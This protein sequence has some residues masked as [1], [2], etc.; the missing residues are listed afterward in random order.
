VTAARGEE[1]VA[2]VPVAAGD[3]L[4]IGENVERR[5]DFLA[6]AAARRARPPH[7]YG[8][9]H[10]TWP[11]P[12]CFQYDTADEAFAAIDKVYGP[13]SGHLV[14]GPVPRRIHLERLA[15]YP[16][17]V[18]SPPELPDPLPDPTVPSS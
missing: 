8:L 12:D 3:S 4:V 7:P 17:D 2:I 16:D 15:S 6:R 11:A 5:A 13:D 1:L 10:P 18:P 9:D 14:I